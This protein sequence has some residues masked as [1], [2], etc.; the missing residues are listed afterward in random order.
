MS[1]PAAPE[2]LEVTEQ[3]KRALVSFDRALLSGTI[4]RM[5]GLLADLAPAANPGLTPDRI[6]SLRSRLRSLFLLANRGTL[7]ASA[8]I[9]R[10]R[11]DE[12]DT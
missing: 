4:T 6:T 12:G 5:E 11:G 2:L 3:I 1:G 8:E 9:E 7:L 10:L